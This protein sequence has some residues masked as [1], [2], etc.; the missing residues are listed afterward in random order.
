MDLTG[1]KQHRLDAKG[2]LT[3]PAEYRKDFQEQIFLVPLPDALCGFTSE[4]YGA[5][6]ASMFPNG[7]NPRDKK[8]QAISRYLHSN[9]VTIDID[10]ASRIA[11][12]KVPMKTR[13]QFGLAG[14]DEIT[15]VGN[16]DH[17]EFWNTEQWAEQEQAM[18][19]A[20]A[21]L[22]YS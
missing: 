18:Q 7:L 20:F 11:L 17:L 9:T 8:E 15:I 6:L 12:G 22:L 3:L 16:G 14:V 1:A 19:E 10:S 5:W 2:R 21:S 4:S 13:E